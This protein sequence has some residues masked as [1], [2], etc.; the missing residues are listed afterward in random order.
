[1]SP[2]GSGCRAAVGQDLVQQEAELV[3]V[4]RHVTA[5]RG[6]AR[7]AYSGVRR[8]CAVRSGGSSPGNRS[9][10]HGRCRSPAASEPVLVDQDVRRLEIA[11]DD[12]TAM[13]DPTAARP[14]P[15]ARAR[16]GIEPPSCPCRVI[17]SRARSST[18]RKG[19]PSP[20][21]SAVEQRGD[22][23]GGQAARGSGA[24][25]RSASPRRHPM[26]RLREADGGGLAESLRPPLR[27]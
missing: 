12:E 5:R 13:G 11:V 19:R 20:V 21:R 18:T 17:G 3:D 22:G 23:R 24:P 10:G 25:A 1:M 4:R 2:S 15:R 9:P 8:R 14:G 6:P 16:R 27:S 26:H 7:L